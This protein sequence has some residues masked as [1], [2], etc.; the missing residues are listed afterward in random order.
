MDNP[1]ST[2][3]ELVERVRQQATTID[4]LHA[5]IDRLKGRL[6]EMA[7]TAR[8]EQA[9]EVGPVPLRRLGIA[10][11]LILIAAIACGLAVTRFLVGDLERKQVW[12]AV[13]SGL[14][15]GW[16]FKLAAGMFAELGTVLLMPCFVTGTIACAALG[17][18]APRP[19]LRR[20]LRQPGTMASFLATVILALVVPLGLAVWLGMGG[21]NTGGTNVLV[22][23]LLA[24]VGLNGAAIALGWLAMAVYGHWRPEPTGLDRLGRV[25][26]AGWIVSSI[27]YAYIAVAYWPF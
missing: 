7:E 11:G 1:S 14:A 18:R 19:P 2:H 17:L 15:R 13:T 4:S 24:G 12:D 9:G 6:D 26:G 27:F 21:K 5:E 25:V 10:D 3:D 22:L 20:F 8:G 16:S 23:L